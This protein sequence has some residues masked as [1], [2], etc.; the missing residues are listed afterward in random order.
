M[1]TKM[2]DRRATKRVVKLKQLSG[3]ATR[4]V[5][6]KEVAATPVKVLQANQRA[7]ERLGKKETTIRGVTV[8][9]TKAVALVINQTHVKG[10]N[11]RIDNNCPVARALRASV[12]GEYITDAHVGNATAK[13]WSVLNP[14]TEVKYVLDANLY[15]AVRKWDKTGKWPLED[16]IYWL[17]PYPRSLRHGYV[18]NPS[19]TRTY[20]GG[21]KTRSPS[22]HISLRTDIRRA[23]S[24][25]VTMAKGA[26]KTRRA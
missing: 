5:R 17:N 4:V 16:G 24:L 22:R 3:S 19:S 23:Q 6:A 7:L 14:D 18:R 20:S 11:R 9:A 12:L 26:K 13:V 8:Y 1:A 15:G 21:K 2:K 25:G 10:A